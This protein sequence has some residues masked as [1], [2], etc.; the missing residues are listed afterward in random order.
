MCSIFGA[1][2][3]PSAI[4]NE[5]VSGL[6]AA[7]SDRG[8]DGFGM[9]DVPLA[10]GRVARLANWRAAPSTELFKARRLQPY[11][12]VL[13]NGTV[14]NDIELGRREG[15]IDSEVLPRVLDRSSASG[16]A[17]SLARIVGSYALAVASRSTVLLACNYKPLFYWSPDDGLTTYFSSLERHF[18]GLLP[19]GN[20]PVQLPPYSVLDL[21]TFE[22]VAVQR[23]FT[24]RAIVVASAGLDSTVAAAKLIADGYEVR[25]LHF[26]YGCQAQ[27]NEL[28]ALPNIAYALGCDLEVLDLPFNHMAGMSPLLS[29]DGQLSDAAAGTEY[30]HEWVPARNLVMLSHATAYAEAN[31]F[32]TIAIG[33]NLEEGGAYPDNEEQL[34]ITFNELLPYAVQNGYRV[35]VVSPLGTLMKHEIVRLGLLLAA[36]L[37]E[38][39][40]CYR[41][42]AKP[43][44]TCS[45]CHMRSIAF[46]R[47]GAQDPALQG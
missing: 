8:R 10:D 22:A 43:C 40:S 42:G 2:G 37:E 24:K 14:A 19:R 5:I 27:R 29:V 35:Q 31:G 23:T 44:G 46:A 16:L 11:D 30:A 45:S 18:N 4:S 21:T 1:L 13:H 6:R 26:R 15:E 32:H 25:L 39:W 17:Q 3:E 47:A 7:A 28:R 41:A 36:P 12:G 34:T 38:T 20:R 9:A 33:N